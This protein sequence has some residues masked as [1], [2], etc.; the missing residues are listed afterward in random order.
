MIAPKLTLGRGLA[1]CAA[2]LAS[3]P[4][5]GAEPQGPT[6]LGSPGGWVTPDDYPRTAAMDNKQGIVRFMVDVDPSGKPVQCS[7][8]QS[9]GDDELDLTAC[10]LVTLRARFAPARDARGRPVAGRYSNSIKWVLPRTLA[11]PQPSALTF[12]MLVTADGTIAECKIIRAEGKSAELIA[13]K[14]GPCDSDSDFEPY[15]DSAGKP[16]AKRITFSTEM[17]VE[18][19]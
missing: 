4:G 11:P 1:L 13:R 18:A 8:V 19:P 7:I 17:K 3:D 5:Q 14:K 15:R 6:P 9:S 16:V 12:T 10:N 2:L